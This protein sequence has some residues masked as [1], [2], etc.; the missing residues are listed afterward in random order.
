MLTNKRLQR[1][2]CPLRRK[3]KVAAKSGWLKTGMAVLCCLLA[4]APG[5]GSASCCR[6]T[7]ATDDKRDSCRS[8]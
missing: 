1:T 5:A 2:G 4:L 7:G 3:C 8:H 6:P